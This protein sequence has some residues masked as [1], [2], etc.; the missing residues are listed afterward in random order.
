MKNELPFV[1]V[2]AKLSNTGEYVRKF[3]LVSTLSTSNV[4]DNM[5]SICEDVHS[6]MTLHQIVGYF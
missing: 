6:E 4:L 5:A 1:N 2:Q 3:S